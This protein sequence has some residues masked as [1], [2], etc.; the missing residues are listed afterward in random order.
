MG[1]RRLA[2]APG[3]SVRGGLGGERADCRPPQRRRFMTRG[4]RGG[5]GFL[6]NSSF[7]R[8]PSHGVPFVPDVFDR[9]VRSYG[10]CFSVCLMYMVEGFDPWHL[11]FGSGGDLFHEILSSKLNIHDPIPSWRV[12]QRSTLGGESQMR[13]DRCEARGSASSERGVAVMPRTDLALASGS[14]L[15]QIRPP[16]CALEI[17]GFRTPPHSPPP[18]PLLR[19]S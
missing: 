5:Q 4:L 8:S 6:C 10:T 7:S 16:I 15:R 19:G 18:Q 13:H 14:F 12:R 2:F 17:R 3:N 1:G 9:R 11:C